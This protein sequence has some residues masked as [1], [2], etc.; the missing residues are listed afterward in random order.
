MSRSI[1]IISL[2][3]VSAGSA[4]AQLDPIAP[5][6]PPSS[7][8]ADGRWVHPN[9]AVF[10]FLADGTYTLRGAPT[11]NWSYADG[12]LSLDDTGAASCAGSSSGIYH[13]TFSSDCAT[14]TL[15]LIHDGCR[16]RGESFDLTTLRR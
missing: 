12:T 13:T 15:G 16:L 3:I 7:C 4:F 5:S 2:V 14:V 10:D 11:G 6:G 8:S 9:G 1:V